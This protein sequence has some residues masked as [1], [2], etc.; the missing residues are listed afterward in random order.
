MGDRG[1][2]LPWRGSDNRVWCSLENIRDG[3]LCMHT[4]SV[5]SY[6]IRYPNPYFNR[7]PNL[8]SYFFNPNRNSLIN[9][10]PCLNPSPLLVNPSPQSLEISLMHTRCDI[11]C[12]RE[13]SLLSLYEQYHISFQETLLTRGWSTW[14]RGV[15]V[16]GRGRSEYSLMQE[17]TL[18]HVTRAF[19]RDVT[20]AFGRDVTHAI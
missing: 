18:Y 3:P 20:H 16:P 10:N 12:M 9:T 15:G 5:I 2:T 6:R 4:E 7:S 13:M 14:E 17:V 1:H 8:N 19:G 11:C